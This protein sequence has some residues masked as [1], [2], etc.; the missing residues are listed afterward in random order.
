MA[1]A[2]PYMTLGNVPVLAVSL[3]VLVLGYGVA[4]RR[5]GRR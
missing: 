3:L 1:G 5:R 4:R 2:T